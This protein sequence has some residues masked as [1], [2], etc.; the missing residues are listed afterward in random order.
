MGQWTPENDSV[1]RSEHIGRRLFDE[2]MLVGARD[3]KPFGGLLLS[4]FE[5]T[6]DDEF[7]LD[8]LGRSSIDRRVVGYLRPLADTAGRAFHTAKRFDGWIV[9]PAHRLTDPRRRVPLELA[10][11]PDDA[12]R[13]HAHLVTTSLFASE[14]LRHY[15]I[16]LHLKE[17]FTGPGSILHP[18]TIEAKA[19]LKSSWRK[20]ISQWLSNRFRR[21]ISRRD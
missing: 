21:W 5:E 3:Q 6:R 9:L 11:S 10:A 16:A 19:S 13:Y 4:N 7:S 8:R 14:P 2:P 12:N 15:L 20:K 1:G 18:V 17:L